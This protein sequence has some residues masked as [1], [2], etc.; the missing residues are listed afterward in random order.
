MKA[1]KK[2]VVIGGGHGSS[3]VL[4]G[5][6][7]KDLELTAVISMADNGGST[8]RLRREL[9]V[10][11]LGDIRNCLA[12]LCDSA[13]LSSLFSYRFSKG[14]LEG[15]SLGNLFL[16]AGELS[17]GNLQTSI[18][19]AREALSIRAKIFPVTLDKPQL[20]YTAEEREVVGM[21]QIAG[22]TINSKPKLTLEPE[23]KLT[24]QAR[25][26]I[27]EAD[28]III[29]PGNFYCSIAQTLIVG[30]MA[31]ALESTSAKVAMV[32][33]L[34][35]IKNHTKNFNVV[36]YILEVNRL[37][38]R[39][40]LD[41]MVYNTKL[42]DQS[43]LRPNEELVRLDFDKANAKSVIFKGGDLADENLTQPDPNDK[44]AH[45]RSKVRHDNKKLAEI[46]LAL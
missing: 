35:N 37:L 24:E 38:G 34:I 36:D 2:I 17:S 32:A 19:N 8:G 29:A 4:S 13:E 27:S 28:L 11:A 30:G 39:E 20:K 21:H 23:A 45:I 44:I 7:D 10:S 12:A 1:G 43:V 3:V 22:I 6:K 18:D 14:E 15:H 42:L 26:S 9:G 31:E 25:K 33:N 41:Y 46:I 40:V 16:A 5:L